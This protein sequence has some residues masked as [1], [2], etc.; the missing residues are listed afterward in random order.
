MAHTYTALYYHLVFSTKNRKNF[1]QPAI[2]ES[3]WPYLGG[4][5]RYHGMTALAVGGVDDHIHVLLR[6][7]AV[8]SP[9]EIAKYIKGGSSKWV[10]ETFPDLRA[11][12]WQDGYGA[13]AVSKSNVP[14]VISYIGNQ[15]KHHVK[16]TFQDEYI[17][18]LCAHGIEYNI[19]Y[20][21]G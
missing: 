14:R 1:L 15:P 10:L 5:A 4:V 8:I 16:R 11:F 19:Q 17:E 20:L 21:L 6:A 9:S 13:F 12:A 2:T 3:L 7:P 18:L